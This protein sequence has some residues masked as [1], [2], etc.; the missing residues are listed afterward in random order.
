MNFAY[1]IPTT[2]TSCSFGGL[3]TYL[4]LFFMYLV[5]SPSLSIGF[6][7]AIRLHRLDGK[8]V[9]LFAYLTNEIFREDNGNSADCEFNTCEGKLLN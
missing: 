1:S 5:L 2:L 8:G 7:L 4:K 6:S 9:I 3:C